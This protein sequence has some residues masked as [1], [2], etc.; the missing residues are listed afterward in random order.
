MKTYLI[1]ISLVCFANCKT[2]K[3]VRSTDANSYKTTHHSDSDTMKQNKSVA[4]TAGLVKNIIANKEKYINKE[5]GILLNDLSIPVKSYMVINTRIDRLDGIILYFD[6]YTTTIWK[7]NQDNSK[8]P[9][10]LNIIWET[11]VSAV[12]YNALRQKS[13][14]NGNWGSVEQ[15]FYSKQIIKDVH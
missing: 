13:T 3:P 9:S 15:E 10:S 8:R 7:Q 11:P 14:S 12:T 1:L 4:D 2:L 5:L 6:N